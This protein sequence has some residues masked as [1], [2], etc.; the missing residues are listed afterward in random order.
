[1]KTLTAEAMQKA[2][3]FGPIH[4]DPL[5]KNP[6]APAEYTEKVARLQAAVETAPG[7]AEKGLAELSLEEAMHEQAGRLAGMIGRY[8]AHHQGDNDLASDMQ[9]LACKHLLHASDLRE[10][11][12]GLREAAEREWVT[13]SESSAPPPVET[14]SAPMGRS[15]AADYATDKAKALTKTEHEKTEQSRTEIEP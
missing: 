2:E 12:P 4:A 3:Q 10:A 8:A 1:M 7:P 11:L 14:P 15:L 9:D 6:E 13:R 5:F